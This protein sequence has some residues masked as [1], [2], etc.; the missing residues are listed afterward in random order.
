L[1]VGGSRPDLTVILD[2]PAAPGLDRAA[3]RGGA[4]RFESKGLAF[5]ERLRT[6]Y[7]ALAA[8]EPDRCRLIDATGD[9]DVVAAAVWSAVTAKLGAP[10]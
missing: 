8:D 1:V 6:A 4:A 3:G 2:A 9:V 10:A 7:Q 5:H